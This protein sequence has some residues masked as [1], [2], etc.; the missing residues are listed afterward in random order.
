MLFWEGVQDKECSKGKTSLTSVAL[1]VIQYPRVGNKRFSL[2]LQDFRIFP[3]IVVST[4][5]SHL[6]KKEFCAQTKRNGLKKPVRTKNCSIGANLEY[7]YFCNWNYSFW[8]FNYF[9]LLPHSVY[10]FLELTM[11]SVCFSFWPKSK[12]QHQW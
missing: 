2:I 5:L 6:K 10:Q 12:P 9:E 1:I 4:L 3:S 7:I 11:S 8:F